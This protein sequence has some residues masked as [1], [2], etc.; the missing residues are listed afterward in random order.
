[1][2]RDAELSFTPPPGGGRARSSDRSAEAVSF[3]DDPAKQKQWRAFLKRSRL[4][5]APDSLSEVVEELHTFFATIL[6][7]A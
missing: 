7:E 3:G 6:S 4:T 1:M 5:A 2:D